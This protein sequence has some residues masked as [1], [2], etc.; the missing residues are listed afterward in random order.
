MAFNQEQTTPFT[1]TAIK[2]SP[3]SISAPS[4]QS[5]NGFSHEFIYW[6]DGGAPSHDIATT[7]DT[8]V[9]A[10]FTYDLTSPPTWPDPGLEVTRYR[11]TSLEIEWSEAVDEIEVIT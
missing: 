7:E 3:L 4:P 1:Y 2:G 11:D 9:M 5:P 8:S 6:S 10:F